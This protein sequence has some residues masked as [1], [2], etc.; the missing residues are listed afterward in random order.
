[1]RYGDSS[2][3][4][5]QRQSLP[6]FARE[7]LVSS[8][9]TST[10]A[11]VLC[12]VAREHQAILILAV[13]YIVCGGIALFA[14]RQPWP[15][16]LTN[17][18][19]TTTWLALTLVWL[20]IEAV[21]GRRSAYDL[22]LA[23]VGG[24]LLVFLLAVPTQITF[25]SLKESIGP[26]VG[27]PYDTALARADELLHGGPAWRIFAAFLRSPAAMRA[28]DWLYML[29]F[30]ALATVV[31]WLSWTNRRLLRA[32]ALTALLLI[33][34]AG[35]TL[36]AWALASAGPCYSNAPQYRELIARLDRL[37]FPLWARSNQNAIW[38]A[39]QTH[40]LLAFGGISAM[41]SMHVAI[42]VWMALIM[43]ARSRPLSVILAAYAVVVQ[44]GSVIL[45]WHYAIDG[46][47]GAAVAWAAW[48]AAKRLIPPDTLVAT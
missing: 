2:T 32:R 8:P 25:Q 18:W 10:R 12:E 36:G 15:L 24:A 48:S 30:V 5:G 23:R 1:M 9:E 14:L 42:A 13:A 46:Y 28:L 26:T 38:H 31:V 6:S 47:A 33:W 45:G 41:P 35:G 29:W 44:I 43:C 17:P 40:T 16:Q 3:K 21:N 7:P 19:F 11:A 20:G 39:Q 34:I 37:G 22:N 27:F 4:R